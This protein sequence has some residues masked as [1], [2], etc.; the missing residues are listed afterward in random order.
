[1]PIIPF[2]A[3]DEIG[4]L[5]VSLGRGGQSAQGPAGEILLRF[6]G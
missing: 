3:R 1:V 5:A 6:R 4:E 2:R